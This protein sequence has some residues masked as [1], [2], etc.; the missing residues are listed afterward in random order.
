MRAW[1]P[2]VVVV[3]LFGVV[4]PGFGQA[5]DYEVVLRVATPEPV[6]TLNPLNA[7]DTWSWLVLQWIYDGAVLRD[8]TTGEIL[9]YIAVGSA[10]QSN[11]LTTVDWSDCTVGNFGFNPNGT[12]EDEG[13]P[14][15]T[16]FYDFTGVRWHDG[17]QMTI[18]DV[19][20]TYHVI[21]QMPD[22]SASVDSLKDKGGRVGTNY[23]NDHMLNIKQ[24]WKS[25]DGLRAALKFTLQEP[26]AD[27]ATNTLSV[28]LLPYHIW[29]TPEGGQITDTK[30]WID[31][32]YWPPAPDVWSPDKATSFDNPDPVGC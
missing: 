16:I 13:K 2:L 32:G 6:R 19:L 24:V 11:E 26:F 15:A 3:L 31:P 23:P 18:R 28:F 25:A 10:N 7:G 5:Q 21:A 12:W 4:S 14:E 27:F 20:F 30:I 9:P 1:A 29:G 8:V 22:W 17:T